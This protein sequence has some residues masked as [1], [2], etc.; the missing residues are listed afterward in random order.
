[1]GFGDSPPEIVTYNDPGSKNLIDNGYFNPNDGKIYLNTDPK[2]SLGR[3]L[4]TTLDLIFHENSHNYQDKLVK[5]LD[6]SSPDPLDPA[7]P[8]YNQAVLFALNDGPHSYVKGEEN[9]EDYKKQPLE[10]HAHDNGP[11]TA[12]AVMTGLRI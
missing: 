7:D 5:R 4:A 6:P 11:K 12:R 9:F 3:D 1:M 8:E 10:E 2:A